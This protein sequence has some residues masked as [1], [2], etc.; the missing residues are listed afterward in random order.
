DPTVGIKAV[1]EKLKELPCEAIDWTKFDVEFRSTYPDFRDKLLEK[2]P[3][4][5]KMEVK[6]A[7]LLKLKLTSLDISKLLCISERTSE[8]HRHHIRRKMGLT[9]EQD[10]REVL[11]GM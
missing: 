1:R 4:L 5:S 10:I 2:Y 7:S 11:A 3:D 8:E 6:I 9:R